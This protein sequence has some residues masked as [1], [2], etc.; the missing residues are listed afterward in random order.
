MTLDT[1]G[2]KT[3]EREW[4]FKYLDEDVQPKV[5]ANWKDIRPLISKAYAE[6][7]RARYNAYVEA[8][9]EAKR[10]GLSPSDFAAEVEYIRDDVKDAVEEVKFDIVESAL[11]KILKELK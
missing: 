11:I 10:R 2:V 7:Q 9:R 8:N 4:W 5:V 6:I 1:P 3:P